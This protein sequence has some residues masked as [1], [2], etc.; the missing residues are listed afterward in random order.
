MLF[1]RL[2]TPCIPKSSQK[3]IGFDVDI[4]LP[5]PSLSKNNDVKIFTTRYLEYAIDT[6]IYEY[7]TEPPLWR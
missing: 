6:H 5:K 1:N 2:L 4:S 7:A 3:G